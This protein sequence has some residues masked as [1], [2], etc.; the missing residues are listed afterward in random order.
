MFSGFAATQMECRL[1]K[2][3]LLIRNE[4]TIKHLYFIA[5]TSD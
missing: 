4:Q 3:R 5:F 2:P 1:Y